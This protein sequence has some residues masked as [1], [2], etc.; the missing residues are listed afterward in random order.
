M[1]AR[2]TILTAGVAL[3]LVAPAANAAKVGN[4][5]SCAK[6]GTVQRV[7]AVSH[8]FRALQKI[9]PVR[10]ESKAGAK[11]CT[12]KVTTKVGN[13]SPK[14]PKIVKVPF[15]SQI[16]QPAHLLTPPAGSAIDSINLDP[17]ADEYMSVPDAT[18]T[19]AAVEEAPVEEATPEAAPVEEPAV[20]AS[21]VEESTVE[22]AQIIDYWDASWPESPSFFHS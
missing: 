12:Q 5:R 2:T 8:G 13:T 20:E 22:T 14:G 1:K 10:T 15:V 16:T 7:A 11:G 4:A 18:Q 9:L 6:A 21:P 3:A 19:A 17:Y